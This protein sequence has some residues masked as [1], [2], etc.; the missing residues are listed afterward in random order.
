MQEHLQLPLAKIRLITRNFNRDHLIGEGG[1]GEVYKGALGDKLVAVKRLKQPETNKTLILSRKGFMREIEVLTKLRHRNIVT[2]IGWCSEQEEMILVYEYILNGTLADHLYGPASNRNPLTWT[3]R[4]NICIGACQG[5]HHLHNTCPGNSVIIHGD[6]KSSN[7]LL[8]ENLVAKV[9][10][11]GSA[12]Q[13]DVDV[14]ETIDSTAGTFSPGYLDPHVWTTG[15][16]T[17]ASDVY[18]FAVLMVEALSGKRACEESHPQKE[19][20]LS[21]WAIGKIRNQKGEE[22]GSLKDAWMKFQRNDWNLLR[23]CV[24]L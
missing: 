24:C 2:L 17:T 6:V 23:F 1:F 20:K 9:S 5:L 19:C 14:S 4:L 12:K 7:I 3:E 22:I 8:D 18:A 11:F 15:K 21:D 10:D 16:Y 13:I